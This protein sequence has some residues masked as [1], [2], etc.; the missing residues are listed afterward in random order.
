MH[1]IWQTR[2]RSMALSAEQQ[3]QLAALFSAI[4]QRAPIDV[5]LQARASIDDTSYAHRAHPMACVDGADEGV[6]VHE[7]DSTDDGEAVAHLGLR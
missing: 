1:A 5:W 4:E 7:S 6:S 3:Q 2:F